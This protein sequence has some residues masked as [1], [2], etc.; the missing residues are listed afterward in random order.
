[1]TSPTSPTARPYVRLDTLE[2]VTLP[3]SSVLWGPQLSSVLVRTAHLRQHPSAQ[4]ARPFSPYYCLPNSPCWATRIVSASSLPKRLAQIA[5]LMARDGDRCF[6]CSTPLFSPFP[7][8]NTHGISVEH[9]VPKAHG[10]PDHASNLVLT[11]SPCNREMGA[12][13][14]AEKVRRA[15]VKGRGGL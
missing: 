7:V 15:I 5:Y 11:C 6:Y 9:L 13:S 2:E 12:L 8:P 4:D 3:P 14:A 1:M 10:G